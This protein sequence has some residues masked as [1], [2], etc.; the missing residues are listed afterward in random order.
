MITEQRLRF[1]LESALSAEVAICAAIFTAVFLLLIG[2]MRLFRGTTDSA[3]ADN[4]GTG[5]GVYSCRGSYYG[6]AK[7]NPVTQPKESLR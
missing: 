4:S 2:I 5:I 7:P 6:I 1:L 3:L